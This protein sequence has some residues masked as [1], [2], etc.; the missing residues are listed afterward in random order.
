MFGKDAVLQEQG[1]ED[2]DWG[3]SDRRKRKKESDGA[4][5]LVAVCENSKKDQDVK[6]TPEQTQH[7]ERDSVSVE[8]KVG[9]RPMFRIPR[10]AVE[11]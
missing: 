8:G 10:A 3:P 5:T 4:S 1:S 6:E 9:K 7:S 11:V 2:E